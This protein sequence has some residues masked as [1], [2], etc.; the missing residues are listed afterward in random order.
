MVVQ[1]MKKLRAGI[2]LLGIVILVACAGAQPYEYRSDREQAEGG[3][4]ISGDKGYFEIYNR[5]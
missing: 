1:C 4:L 5:P 3:G 2:V